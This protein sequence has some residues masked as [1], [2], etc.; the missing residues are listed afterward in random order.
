M[1]PDGSDAIPTTVLSLTETTQSFHFDNIAAAP[2]ASLLR[3]YSAPVHLDFEQGD[4]ELAHLMAHD[5]D[6][7]NRWEAGQRLATRALL[8][9]IARRRQRCRLD[10]AGAGRRLRPHPRRRL[11]AAHRPCLRRRGAGA[12]ARTGAG[13]G[14][15]RAGQDDRSGCHPPRTRSNCA[16]I[17]Q[18]RCFDAFDALWQALAPTEPYAPEGEQVGRRALRNA[19]LAYL[20]EA[21]QQAALPRLMAQFAADGAAT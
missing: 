19:C 3:G 2:V 6:A 1:L 13:R 20:A 4:D 11:G 10:S 12:A 17:W 14:S 8:A 9:G 16:A 18:A 5:S 21:D 7:F 15:R